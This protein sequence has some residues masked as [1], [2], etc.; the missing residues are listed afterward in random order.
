MTPT[1]IAIIGGGC[2]G[3][4]AAIQLLRQ[5]R[6]QSLEIFIV[7]KSQ[8]LGR[9]LA[10]NVPSDRCKLNVPANSM[11]AF[12]DDPAGFHAWLIAHNHQISG[13]E[14]VSRDLFGQYIEDTLATYR[15][16]VAHV[17]VT[18][19]HDEASDISFEQ[20]TNQFRI[21]CCQ[22]LPLVADICV[23][24]LGNL[25][26]TTFSG[27][28]VTS[29][30]TS[31]YARDSYAQVRNYSRILIIGTGLTAIDTLLESEGRGFAGHYTMVSRNGLLPLPHETTKSA[32]SAQIS[33]LMPSREALSAL[34][35]RE[36]T[37]FV[38][39]ESRRI[40]S[41][42]P[43]I[44]ALR[45]YVQEIWTRFSDTDKRR[46]LRHLRPLWEIQR[47][48]IPKAHADTV[49]QLVN[50]NR[51]SVHAGAITSFERA[52]SGV[53]V[54]ITDSNTQ[55]PHIF[56]VAFLCAGP[57]SDLSKVQAPLIKNL[58]TR[59]IIER[60]ALGLGAHPTRTSLPQHAR[61][62]FRILG[63]LQ[64]EALWEITAVREIRVEAEHIARE[65]LELIPQISA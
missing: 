19:I 47:H 15:S 29:A 21:S 25:A 45:P 51:L 5:M 50:S 18:H 13:D 28:A 2:S 3:T 34:S 58:L 56:D 59:G 32:V 26:R 43:A 57:E 27:L 63:P 37:H 40:G 54:T 11:G 62:R 60:G 30:L 44:A 6:N 16:Q 10:Y 17:Q 7:E 65:V 31:P 20:S 14:F 9:G 36:L 12:A 55:T 64:R 8:V 48:R 39:Q 23:L 42:Q 33:A 52:S 53:N 1:R 4:L 35:L 46:F 61:A 41:S 22:T 24:A 49:Q 38:T